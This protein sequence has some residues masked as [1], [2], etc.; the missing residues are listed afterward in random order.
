M[1]IELKFSSSFTS[2]DSIDQQYIC[3]GRLD[4]PYGALYMICSCIEDSHDCIIASSITFEVIRRII[5]S[6]PGRSAEKLLSSAI[7]E[8]NRAVHERFF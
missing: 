4:T 2:D 8:A 6:A 5:T 1:N 7:R 3:H